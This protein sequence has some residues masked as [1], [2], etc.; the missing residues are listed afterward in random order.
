MTM[1]LIDLDE[2][3]APPWCEEFRRL[4]QELLEG[5][6][7]GS[8]YE[9]RLL[10]NYADDADLL[11]RRVGLMIDRLGDLRAAMRVSAMPVAP[12]LQPLA[13]QISEFSGTADRQHADHSLA[14]L[15]FREATDPR[16]TL[17]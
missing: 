15:V 13:G 11:Y 8:E 4:A 16:R 17:R 2:P 10:S 9:A 14:V 3:A 6:V 5:N 12:V 1:S 7:D